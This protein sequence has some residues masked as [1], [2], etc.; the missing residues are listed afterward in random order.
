MRFNKPLV[1]IAPEALIAL[2]S[3]PWPGNVRELEN[4][5][6]TA[7]LCCRGN[8]ITL[9]DLPEAVRR[10]GSMAAPTADV[11]VH[12]AGGNGS[13]NDSR[14]L[15]RNRAEYERSL[16]QKTLEA[17]QNNRSYAARVLGISRVTLH[18]KINQ[19]RLNGPNRPQG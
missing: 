8:E 11:V 9:D 3:C 15:L 16:I 4:I 10:G 6:Q 5:I 12:S 14:Y 7:V 18:K 13:A 19:Y 17:C 2:T 1:D